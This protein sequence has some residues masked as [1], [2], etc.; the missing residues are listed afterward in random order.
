MPRA[1]TTFKVVVTGPFNA[2]KTTLI[3]TISEIPVLTTE[4]A[5]SSGERSRKKQTTVSMD[6]GRLTI[7][8]RPVIELAMFGTPGQARFDFMWNV[9]AKGML[10]YVLMVDV[11]DPST[12]GEATTILSHFAGL[13]GGIAGPV[14]TEDGAGAV[15]CIVGANRASG[16]PGEVQRLREVLRLPDHLQTI[17]CNVV[18]HASARDVLLALLHE[19]LARIEY[20]SQAG[21]QP[22][23]EPVG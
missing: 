6:F 2:G 4:T 8:G 20:R 15:P 9:L 11:S 21:A 16:D 19:V 12:W 3:S 22:A 10:G 13:G 1:H 18:E 14:G 7:P 17:P 5:V 23:T